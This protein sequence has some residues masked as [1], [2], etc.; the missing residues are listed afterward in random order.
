MVLIGNIG[1]CK[2]KHNQQIRKKLNLCQEKISRK[3]KL[4]VEAQSIAIAAWVLSEA[5]ERE[6][7]AFVWIGTMRTLAQPTTRSTTSL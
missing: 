3:S 2:I 5:V 4:F 7:V 1:S 6:T